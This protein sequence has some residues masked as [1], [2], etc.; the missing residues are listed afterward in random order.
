MSRQNYMYLTAKAGYMSEFK[1]TLKD[2]LT[3]FSQ[4]RLAYALAV[5]DIAA[6]YRGSILGPWWI[7]ITMGALVFGIGINYAGLFH[8]SVQELLPYVAGGIVA[9]GFISGTIVEGGDAFVA[10]GAMLRQSSLPLPLF[11]ARCLLR[12]LINLAHHVVII[13][14]VLAY[15]RH[16]P[17]F[18]ILWSLA[19]LVLA[20]F[21]L[22]WIM[23]L[24]AFL[25]S[26]FR[27]VPQIIAA[28]LQITFFL[29]PVFWKATPAMAA[30]PI[31]VLNPFYYLL[32]AIRRPLLDGPLPISSYLLLLA[33][34]LLGWLVTILV[35]NLT[36]RRV[37]HYL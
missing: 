28:V 25:S 14:L 22:G 35:Y 21:N 6:R 17:G 8:I 20:V 3:S 15:V 1:E 24:V 9:W 36:R 23:I 34:G 18:G 32:E 29:T 11:I 30:S 19:G 4:W 26:R 37:V 33:F 2:F 13:A 7:T 31:V 5:H 12:N 27:D 10:G 16:F